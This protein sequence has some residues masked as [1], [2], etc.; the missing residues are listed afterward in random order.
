MD[1]KYKRT[2]LTGTSALIK[3]FEEM[4]RVKVGHI[5][6]ITDLKA[7]ILN[8]GGLAGVVHFKAPYYYLLGYMEDGECLVHE[9]LPNVCQLYRHN[10]H[11]FRLHELFAATRSRLD[12]MDD[13]ELNFL[14]DI[15]VEHF[16][17]SRQ[18]LK[19]CVQ[20]TGDMKA[21]VEKELIIL[22]RVMPLLKDTGLPSTY[23]EMR[24]YLIK[25]YEID[26]HVVDK[27]VLHQC[28][29]IDLVKQHIALKW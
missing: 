10:K 16:E 28:G 21:L 12:L 9:L 27:D 7:P 3:V 24:E 14:T 18:A 5:I 25:L 17:N 11:A 4:Y 13:I 2:T 26:Y 23:E 29:L 1:Q 15:D 20:Y 6:K 19:T 8:S 22:K